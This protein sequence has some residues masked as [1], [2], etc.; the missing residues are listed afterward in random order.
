MNHAIAIHGGAG[1]I[2]RSTMTPEREAAYTKALHEALAVGN[3]ILADGGTSLDAVVAAV[4]SLEDCPLFNAGR[5]SVFNSAGKHEMD[6][7]LMRG[8][9]RAA[10][11]VAG[12]T[13]IR[14]PIGLA[15]LVMEQS[16][17][18]L[19]AGAGAELF[20]REQGVAFEPEEY[21]YVAMRYEQWQQAQQEE[22]IFLDHH[23]SPIAE[24][25]KMGTVGAV[26]IDNWGHLAAAT[27][28]GGMT[29]KRYGRVGDTPLIGAGTY[30][31]DETCAVSCTGHGELFIRAVTAYDVAALMAY[32]HCTLAE[33]VHRVVKQKLVAIGGEGGLIAIDKAGNIELGFNSEGMYR[34]YLKSDGSS[35]IGIYE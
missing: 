32:T 6:A 11:A 13:G 17:H 24:G 1:T 26:A 27:S 22:G 4:T 33:A 30:A 18:V 34:G 14:N 10:G 5:G 29:N 19:M 9:D 2:L 20:A 8:S 25:K 31:D 23:T 21:F 16:P 35:Y 15:R 7:S 12:V 3:K 28:T